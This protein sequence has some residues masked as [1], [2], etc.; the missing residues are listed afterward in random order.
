ME[1]FH[2]K[3]NQILAE[4]YIAQ[5]DKAKALFP[6]HF[7]NTED[8]Q[9]RVNWL[10][11]GK[12]SLLADRGRLVQVLQT[13]NKRIGNAQAAIDHI[14]ALADKDTLAIVGG[15]QA[16]LFGGQLLV[17]YKA[18]TIL[19]LA[20]EWS[21][22]LQR[23]VVPIFWIAGEDHDFDEVNHMYALSN[24]QQ[25]EKIKVDHPTGRRT[26]VSRLPIDPEAWQDALTALDQSLM[27]T[28]FKATLIAK[29]QATTEGGATL[30]DAFA[31]WMA[32]L[33]GEYGL[34]LIDSDEPSLRA[35]ESS[36]FEQLVV[37]NE[38][39]TAS[40][41]KSQDEVKH[42]GYGVQAEITNDGANLFVFAGGQRLLLH[43]ENEHFTDK[44]KEYSFTKE[45]LHDLAVTTPEQ[46]SNN[47]MSRPLMQEFLFPVLATVLGPGEIAYWALTKHAFEQFGMKMPILAPRLEFT[48]IEGTVQKQMNKYGFS[49]EDVL[50]RF[51][52]KKQEWLDAQDTLH[53]NE[54]FDAVKTE[55]RDIYEPLVESLAVINPGVKKLGETN[56]MKILEQI[57]FLHN[58][59]GEAYKI[60]FEATLRQLE[61]IRLTILPLAKPQE[62]VY[63]G[64]AYM[65][66]YGN[67]WLRDLLETPVPVDGLHRV[68]YL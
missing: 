12:T 33:F 28:E 40:L 27:D 65:N 38:V 54:R 35:L 18:I 64:C 67:D 66:R 11:E 29:L 8:W 17:L 55:F 47:V 20:R 14:A 24:M 25:I 46:L 43:R 21:G 39:L 48:L 37:Q 53:L 45:Q 1:T 3:K 58:K 57:D 52:R 61:R 49:F 6:F 23:S 59:A 62:R 31:R 26:S 7:G 41:L 44:K 68:Y 13:Y 36:M 19:Q 5:S 9:S 34:V 60:Q 22:K 32:I 10:D 63:N 42:A 50:E 16:G 56:M 4:D 15:Q 30:S 2:W 51:E